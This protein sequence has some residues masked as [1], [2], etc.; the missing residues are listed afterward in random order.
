MTLHYT[1][2]SAG[3]GKTTSIE[4]DVTDKLEKGALLPSQIMAVTFTK[5]AAAELKERISQ[6][7]LKKGQAELAVGIMSARVGTI[8]SVFGQLLTDF[9]FELG[10]S[11][12]QRVLDD[13]DKFQVLSEALDNSLTPAQITQ[14]NTLSDRLCVEEWRIDILKIIE[15]MRS[16]NLDA[17]ALA[18]FAQQSISSLINKL[19]TADT[20][21]TEQAFCQTLNSAI[22]DANALVKPTKGVLNSIADCET[23][24]RQSSMQWKNWLKVSKLK[25]TKMGEPIFS[26]AM[27][28]GHTVLKCP[29]FRDE[30]SEFI[31]LIMDTAADVMV[32]FATIKQSRGLVDF[33]DQEQLALTALD[34]PTVQQ[35][36]KDEIA[37][38]IVDEFQDTSPIQLALFS[39]MSTLV[40]DV[41]MVG[42]AK[43][44]IYGFR[45]SDPILALN[46]LKHVEAGAGTTNSLP[47][48]WRSRPGLVSLCNDLFNGPFSHIL[49]P[50]Q[51]QLTAKRTDT[52]S[53]PELGWW[54]LEYDGRFRND[55]TLSALAEGIREHILSN[56]DVYDKETR[57]SRIATWRDVAVLCR[58]NDEAATLAECCAQIGIPVSLERSGLLETPEV[59]LA[60]ACLRRLND[61]G[62]S[63]A[64][65]EILT[66]ATGNGPEQWLQQRI[67]SV[68]RDTS[69]EWN[70][71]AHPALINLASTRKDIGLLSTKEALELALLSADV[72]S[73][74]T[75]WEE[76]PKLADH[77]L[78][79]LS[80]LSE[81][82]DDYENHCRAQFLA[83]TPAGYILWLK[84]LEQGFID[85]QAANPGNAVTLTTY[86][87]AKGY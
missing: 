86:H 35:R 24:L 39:K 45:G 38:L 44:A 29:L 79:N 56:V 47:H 1:Q 11:P 30:L 80:K 52:L 85:R 53:S 12:E 87:R 22:T 66:L 82:V 33:I 61:A 63:L 68:N 20:A 78:A 69:Y 26:A 70:D 34:H 28:L 55:K 58:S 65:A 16:N 37:Y 4:N 64:S 41:L 81:L 14:L 25:P 13:Q 10:L 18:G 9:A 17:S 60:L 77:R 83:A 57:T 15:L 67:D 54:T 73:I 27:A 49:K 6:K 40:D 19:P 50:D 36:L 3:S 71:S 21:I 84:N 62:D 5:D 2:A 48:S 43:Q 74:I 42:D 23:I 51:V 8:H 75:Q 32:E 76:N 59:S 7:L 46:V 72:A 31:T